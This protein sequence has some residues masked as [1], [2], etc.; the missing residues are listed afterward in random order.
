VAQLRSRFARSAPGLLFFLLISAGTAWA[1]QASYSPPVNYT[2]QAAKTLTLAAAAVAIALTCWVLAARRRRLA[3]FQSRL[4]LFLGVCVLPLPVMLMSTAVGL[5][6]AKAVEFCSSCHVMKTFV[7]DMKNPA[8]ASL[9][10]RHF[11]N[12]YIQDDHCYTCH[13]DYGLFGTL[14]AKIAGIGH[15]WQETAGTYRLPVRAKGGYHY[16]VCLNCHGLSNR[17]NRNANHRR[18]LDKVLSGEAACTSCHVLSHPKPA[19]RSLP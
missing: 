1:Q 17:F 18:V 12:R 10:A 15:I 7:A 8:S 4:A 6:Q 14:Q 5:E 13:T 9:A 2:Q 19:E 3:A 16:S 11:Q